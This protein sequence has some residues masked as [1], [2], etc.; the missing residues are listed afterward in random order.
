VPLVNDGDFWLADSDEIVKWLETTHPT[1]SMVSTVPADVVGGV[2][3]AFRGAL[4]ATEGEAAAKVTAFEAELEKINAYLAANGPYLGGSVLD[5]TGAW[6][7]PCSGIH[8]PLT[9]IVSSYRLLAG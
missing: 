5:S 7:V 8:A 3:G 1:P 6:H 9:R 4:T 2:F